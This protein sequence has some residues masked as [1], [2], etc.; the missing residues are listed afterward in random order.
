MKK[1]IKLKKL[2]CSTFFGVTSMWEKVVSDA[3]SVRGAHYSIAEYN[4]DSL[5]KSE[6]AKLEKE[7]IEREKK[8]AK[9]RAKKITMTV[10]EFE[11]KLDEASG[12]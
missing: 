2:E 8:E 11:D 3:L 1:K 9:R 6:K 5:T 7:R 12:Y 10:G 4:P